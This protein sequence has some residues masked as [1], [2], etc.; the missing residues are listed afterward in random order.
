MNIKMGTG[1]FYSP[2]SKVFNA[3]DSISWPFVSLVKKPG[4][5][6]RI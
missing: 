4:V 5:L 1:G 2:A 3:T 6:A